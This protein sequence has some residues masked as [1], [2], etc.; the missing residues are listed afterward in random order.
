M[1]SDFQSKMYDIFRF[2]FDIWYSNLFFINFSLKGGKWM[3]ES[4][5]HFIL[6]LFLLIHSLSAHDS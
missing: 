5:E 6:S 3:I 4:L 2:R 1:F